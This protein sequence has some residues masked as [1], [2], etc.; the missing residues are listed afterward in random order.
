MNGLFSVDVLLRQAI[1]LHQGGHLAAAETV[2][3]QVLG[4][5]PGNAEILVNCALAQLGQNKID[6]AERSLREAIKLK[7]DLA[8]AHHR[9]GDVLCRKGQFME[10]TGA[11]RRAIKINPDYS[12]AYNNLGNALLHTG[13]IQ[14]ATAAYRRATQLNPSM[15]QAHNNLGLAYLDMGEIAKS[16]AS[17]EEAIKLAPSYAEAHNNLGRALHLE[18]QGT[19]ARESFKRAIVAN[20]KLSDA[21]ANMA[22]SLMS[23][24]RVAEAEKAAHYAI[25]LNPRDHRAYDALGKALWAQGNLE[26]AEV[27]YRHAIELDS[28][29]PDSHNFLAMV[30]EEAGRLEEAFVHFNRHAELTAAAIGE[31]PELKRR[32]DEE[33]KEWLQT[34]SRSSEATGARISVAA[35]NPFND[36]TAI[37]NQWRTSK[38]QIVVIDDLL[39]PAALDNLRN[40]SLASTAWRKAFE[41]GYIGAL[42]EFG[43]AA[44]LIAQIAEELRKIYPALIEEHPLLHFWGFKYDSGLKGIRVHA[45]FAAVNVNFW[46]TPD[47]ANLDPER[48]GLVVWDVAAPLDWDFTKY[49][50]ADNDIRAFLKDNNAKSIRIPYRANRAVIFDSD[51]FHETDE[52]HFK[53]GY[54]NR[55]VNITLLFG[56]RKN[57][58]DAGTVYPMAIKSRSGDV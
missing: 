23:E 15:A 37:S 57:S 44:P 13:D 38:P 21:H 43:F 20:P 12:E 8:K 56:R 1:G 27:Y 24:G 16:K 4:L 22:I 5:Q 3:V 6:S 34:N 55:R 2:Y 31:P 48:G 25:Q 46:I 29:Y 45:D 36:V 14:G 33:Q 10:A 41:D 54:E 39:T 40:F 19:A 17:F 42:P 50:S 53:P 26:R 49:N 7:G 18:G 32:H 47:E 9:L 52:I 35:V 58:R 51:L 30:L 28:D 11:Y